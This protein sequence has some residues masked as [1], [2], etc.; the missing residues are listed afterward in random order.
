MSKSES[1]R[2]FLASNTAAIRIN[3]GEIAKM[4]GC[5]RQL[6]QRVRA[7]RNVRMKDALERLVDRFSRDLKRIEFN[8][9]TSMKRG[10]PK[11]RE[12]QFKELLAPLWDRV[13]SEL[14]AFRKRVVDTIR[15]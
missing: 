5:T 11:A 10:D 3:D 14:S 15:L 8:Y 12:K 6:V 13:F 2:R 4:F 1:V 9:A 7:Q